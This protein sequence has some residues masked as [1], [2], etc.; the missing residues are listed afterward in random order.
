M[1]MDVLYFDTNTLVRI[2]CVVPFGDWV[3]G[4]DAEGQMIVGKEVLLLSVNLGED[5]QEMDEVNV[6]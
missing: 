4:R 3:V 2:G 5:W 6:E 1:F